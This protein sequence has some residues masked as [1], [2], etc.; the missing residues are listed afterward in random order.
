MR[1]NH[2]YNSA[3]GP[4]RVILFICTDLSI[5]TS[6][7]FVLRFTLRS[8]TLLTRNNLFIDLLISKKFHS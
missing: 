1:Q 7:S 8:L 2:F 5:E 4:N 3:R 6:V